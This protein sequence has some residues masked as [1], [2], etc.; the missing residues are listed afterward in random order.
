MRALFR[1]IYIFEILNFEIYTKMSL[2]RLFLK[3][4]FVFYLFSGESECYTFDEELLVEQLPNSFLEFQ[5]RFSSKW[6]RNLNDKGS[7]I[8]IIEVLRLIYFFLLLLP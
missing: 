8:V 1:N 3:F 2:K 7:L 6:N 4:L 5:F